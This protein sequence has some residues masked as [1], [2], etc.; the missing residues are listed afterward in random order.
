[1]QL[2]IIRG[3]AE[4]LN[5]TYAT[6]SAASTWEKVTYAPTAVTAVTTVAGV[7]LNKVIGTGGNFFVD[8][9]VIY[10]DTAVDNT[11]PSPPTVPSVTPASGQIT[12]SWTAASGGVDNG[13]YMVVRGTS[14]P[15]TAPNVNGI[16]ATGNTVATG[17]TVVY[18][19]TDTTFIDTGLTNGTPYYYRIY[20][21]DKAYNYSSAVTASATPAV[22]TSPTLTAVTLSSALTCTYPNASSGVSFTAS[23]SNLT[24]SSITATAQTGYE[25]STDNSTYGSSVSV[26]S[27]STV[28][29]RFAA[30]RAAGNYN[31]ATAVVLSGGGASSNVNVTTSSSSNTVSQKALTITGASA[32]S[33][34]YNGTTT[35]TITGGS[36][37]TGSGAG[38]VLSA[39]AANVTLG[40][41]PTATVSSK[42][43]G[44]GK[45]VTVTGYSLS[46]TASGNYTVTQP[47]GLT[48]DI[49]AKALSVTAPTIASKAY[50]GTT[51]AGAVTVGTLS[52]FVG[53]ETVTA[54][55][56]A[57]AYSSANVG[58]YN[59][60]T[61]TYTLANGT[62]GGLATN[63]TLANGTGSGSV[64]AKALTITGLS[65]S[66]KVFDGTTSVSVTGTP[67]YSVLATGETF[68]VTGTVTWVFP[69]ASVANNKTLTRTGNYDAP[70][71]NYTVTQPSLQAS[72]TQG[73]VPTLTVAPGATVDNS[74]DVTFTET[75]SL[76][77]DSITSITVGGM[78]LGSSAYS[79]SPG[80]ITF[81]PSA[82]TLLQSS[83]SK[84]IV[85]IATGF[86]NASV[87]QTIN[88]G[89]ATK[90]A[91]TTQPTA[92]ASN[93]ALLATQPVVKVQDQYGN[94]VTGSSASITA[95]VDQGTWTIGGTTSVSASSGVA[96][97]SNLTASSADTV[98]GGTIRFTSGSLTAITSS[99]FNLPI[100]ND[101]ASGAL[102]LTVG[103]APASGKFTGASVSFSPASTKNDVWFKFV[104]TSTSHVVTVTATGTDPDIRIYE[105]TG[106]SYNVAPTAYTT[107][108]PFLIG[109][110]GSVYEETVIATSFVVGRTYFV[111][112]QDFDGAGGTFNIGV[113]VP[114][115]SIATWAPTSWSGTAASPLD[116]TSSDANLSSKSIVRTGLT[117]GSSG[118]RHS[119]AGWNTTANYLQM[120]LTAASGFRMDLNDAVIYGNWGSSGTGPAYY[121]V[122]SSLDNYVADIGY[123]DA[124]STELL[125]SFK[126]PSSGYGQLSTV[127][128]R[129]YGSSTPLSS[130]TTTAS[131]G[132]GGFSAL[133]V[134]G[135]LVPIPSVTAATVAG[136]V[137]TAVNYNTVASGSPT[138]YAIS[139]GT[140]PAGLSLN[141]STGAITGTPTAAG[142]G[143]VVAV[144]ASNSAGTSAAA[145]LTFNI[146]KGT[147]I[148]SVAPTASAITYG[149]TLASSSLTVGIASTPGTYAFTTPSTA[150]NSG[151]ASQNVTFTPT[152]GANYNTAT[153][154]VSVTVNAASLASNQITLTPGAGNSY[155]ASGPVGSTFNY[156]YAGRSANGIATSYSS[157]SAPTAP[158]YY[159]V[160]ATATGN[161]SGSKSADYFVAGPV[162]VADSL[163]KPAD[164]KP[165][166][167]PVSDLLGNDRRI[168]STGTVETTGLTATEVRAGA[169]SA[170]RIVN[171]FVQ[172]TPSSETTDTFTYTV[173]DGTK[174][175]TA[176]VT[177]TTEA[178]A[179]EFRLQIV[180][181]GTVNFAG[182]NTTV[183]HDFIGVPNQTYLVEYA[184]D[185]NG[186]W[187]SAGNQ[188]TGATGSF[189]VTFTKAGDF[190]ADWTAH[191][192][193]RAR[194]VR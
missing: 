21:F 49:T 9:F 1:M 175:A 28:Y 145:N 111:M 160:T 143:T 18:V 164:N 152:D 107:P 57:A 193:F 27:G 180:K 12:V 134:T 38:Q 59:N 108:T 155:A 73:T 63:Y 89:A 33:R 184:T 156:S 67:A 87:S 60:V 4:Q 95:A 148:I 99:S 187:I 124:G 192:Y 133:R 17:Q 100:P 64:T 126:L 79:V 35:I 29:V 61:I 54:T 8:D 75:S 174:S 103:A 186:A 88:P 46:G 168:T 154:M 32:T 163:T 117:G 165:Y 53:S 14:D 112:V 2:G 41:S 131:T 161:Y 113:K 166:T 66:S 77:R 120:T 82:S 189:S 84:T 62:G 22:P 83:G 70:S 115:A 127:T 5:G 176:T 139:S 136:T 74:F 7:L 183:T 141:T 24:G 173:S 137:G 114:P 45:T 144:T 30:S 34:V 159:T 56:A 55:G 43:V 13:G 97:F 91:V 42:D 122:R 36:L 142:N 96:T 135:T 58:T 102:S 130:G 185:L 16:Y 149:Q 146:A 170:A 44:S 182:G 90:L 6:V 76:W 20:T 190:A 51:T 171:F 158:G 162:A 177:I 101:E 110:L 128:F 188:S 178:Q 25:V 47:T 93:G 109:Q 105:G 118:S 125:G 147:P 68:P 72:I 80:K 181:L 92:P 104:A 167:I 194:L 3:G 179:P 172:F 138:S 140:L 69:D 132:T 106:G 94:T 123:F 153:T 11:A 65:A 39:D 129:I 116:A 85:V 98:I 150:P 191:M 169:G 151:T 50:D 48:A 121:S 15:N 78:T 86:S 71:A 119:S 37:T 19:G 31:S 52:G 157:A 40:G 23:G 10:A 26:A 81:S